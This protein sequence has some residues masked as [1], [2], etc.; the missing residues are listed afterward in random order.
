M[1]EKSSSQSSPEAGVGPPF[2]LWSADEAIGAGLIV[3]RKIGGG[4]S[5]I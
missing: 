2:L 4:K 1:R 3:S 5:L